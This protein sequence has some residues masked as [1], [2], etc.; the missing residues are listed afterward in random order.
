M[1]SRVYR[2]LLAWQLGR[3]LAIE[4]YNITAGPAFERDWTFK[5]QLRRCALSVP[6]N[7]AEG[8]ERGSD[9]DCI[10]FLYIARA[11]LAELA[12]Q[13]EIA[14]AVGLLDRQVSERRMEVCDRIARMISGLIR[15]RRA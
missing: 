9:R 3:D 15:H 14:T 10:R 4:V 11:S 12:T 1:E 7:I 5:E 8:N 2:Q 6:S 13:A